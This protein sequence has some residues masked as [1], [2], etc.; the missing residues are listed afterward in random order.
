[1]KYFSLYSTI[2]L[3][4][5]ATSGVHAQVKTSE[6]DSDGEEIEII[7]EPVDA[8]N[9]E[10]TIIYDYRTRMGAYIAGGL[11]DLVGG[12]DSYGETE[13]AIGRSRS[14]ELGVN[15]ITRLSEKSNF[16][17]IKYGVAFQW[18]RLAPHGNKYLVDNAGVNT[19]EE[20]PL[21]LKKS[22]L[23]YTN[24]V[25]PVYFEFGPSKRID[26]NGY[27]SFSKS[28]QFK[29]GIGAY[30]GM[31]IG[32]MQKLKYKED[33]VSI[34][35]KIKRDYNT[36]DFVYGVGAYVGYDAFSLFAKYDLSPLYKDQPE[37]KRLLSLGLR[38]DLE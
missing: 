33:G 34:K 11:T 13:N 15:W 24:V 30:A 9:G 28:N 5:L 12:G 6:E 31:N 27:V 2:V 21:N 7:V 35:N 29:I 4:I 16:F 32:S 23:R 20:Y 1:M 17:R 22:E 19:Y 26:D 3:T 18:N 37:D 36:T 38:I 8:N 25:V 10:K 14:L